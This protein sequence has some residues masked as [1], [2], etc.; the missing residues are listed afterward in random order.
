MMKDGRIIFSE[1][2]AYQSDK[3]RIKYIDPNGNELSEKELAFL[4]KL[5]KQ[6]REK[7]KGSKVTP[8]P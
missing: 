4:N 7:A 8:Q 2:P 3:H 1:V 6:T 5:I